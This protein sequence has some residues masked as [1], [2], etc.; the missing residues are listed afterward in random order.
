MRNKDIGNSGI[1]PTDAGVQV[2]AEVQPQ[3]FDNLIKVLLVKDQFRISNKAYHGFTILDEH[4]LRSCKIQ[5]EI[6]NVW[7]ISPVLGD[8]TGEHSSL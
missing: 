3:S 6:N 5:K 8:S 7:K 1:L 2:A 4:L